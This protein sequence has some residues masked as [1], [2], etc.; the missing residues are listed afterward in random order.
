MVLQSTRIRRGTFLQQHS[1]SLI[2]TSIL[3]LW[4][5]LYKYADPQTHIGA[6]YGN[7]IADWTGTLVIVVLTK[8]FFEQ[9]SKESRR[10]RPRGRSWIRHFLECHSLTIVLVISGVAWAILYARIDA[11]GKTGQV[12]GNIVSEWTQVLG[13]VLITKYAREVGSKESS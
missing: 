12:V 8:Y 11:N 10:P 1:L 13:L 9:G 3:A 7:A 5:V 4:I 6:F 2:V